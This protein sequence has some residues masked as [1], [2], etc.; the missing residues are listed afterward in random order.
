MATSELAPSES[1]RSR[2]G[3]RRLALTL[4]VGAVVVFVFCWLGTFIPLS[5]PTHAYIPLFTAAPP[6]SPAA[7]ME[8]SVW[9]FLFGVLSGAILAVLY[10]AFEGLDR[11]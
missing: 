9:S 3:I 1:P 2:I 11:R 10:N 7:L 6:S 4:G 8:G 5:S